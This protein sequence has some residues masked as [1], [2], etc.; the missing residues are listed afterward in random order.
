MLLESV[1]PVTATVESDLTV[2]ATVAVLP[3][4]VFAV[5]VA[6]PAAIPFTVPFDTV[7]TLVL[8]LV[9][10]TVLSVASEGLTVA[11]NVSELPFVI[12]ADDLFKLIPVTATVELVTVTL[13]EAVRPLLVFAVIV[14]V[15]A[16]FPVTFPF[17]TEAI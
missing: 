2:T 3:L 11:V 14:A 8:L 5:I 15:P 12:V 6:V 17:D 7:A 13:Q 4:F 16:L 1:M 9:H 10:V